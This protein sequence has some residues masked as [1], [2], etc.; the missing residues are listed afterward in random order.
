MFPDASCDIITTGY[1]MRYIVWHWLANVTAACIRK[2]NWNDR[3]FGI[4]SLI[5][6]VYMKST[7]RLGSTS[8]RGISSGVQLEL[9]VDTD[10]THK[11]NWRS[12]SGGVVMCGGACVSFFSRMQTRVTLSS[13]EAECG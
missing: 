12:V 13:T 6:L 1:E 5:V 2:E 8:Q 10:C 11:A 4:L 3:Y 9:S 7:S